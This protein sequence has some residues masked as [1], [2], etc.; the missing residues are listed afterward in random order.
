MSASASA[1]NLL[2]RLRVK[3]SAL[4]RGYDDGALHQLRV[5]L[6]RLRSLLR[7]IESDEAQALR[8]DLGHLADATNAARDW[9]TL[10][11]RARESLKPRDFRS[12]RVW[13]EENRGTSHQQA[14]QMLRSDAW[15]QVM[16]R[17]EESIQHGEL[18]T[19]LENHGGG[20]IAR[21]K[22]AADRAWSR[23]Q[24]ADDNKQWHKLR[25]AIKELRYT[26]DSVPR[27]S[28]EA[29]KPK[30]IKHCKRLQDE[31]GVWHDTV[32]HVRMVQEFVQSLDS[33]SESE[34]HDVLK[35]WCEQMEREA[36]DTL[37][38]ARSLLAGKGSD[39]LQ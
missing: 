36:C 34:L 31:L 39:L 15:S 29:P 10:A 27:G 12:V 13:L 6:R 11:S 35:R 25:L 30:L 21:A 9:D 14:L 26:F 19:A 37:D 32:V 18:A 16:G 28:L 1:R 5:A 20:D 24:A 17:L 33:E 3:R 22:R 23:V 2:L 4:L 8:R 38:N 7:Y